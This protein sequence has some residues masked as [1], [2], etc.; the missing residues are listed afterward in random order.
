ML[1]HM[2]DQAEYDRCL[3]HVFGT[4]KKLGLKFE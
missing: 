1:E 2:K 4:G 3:E